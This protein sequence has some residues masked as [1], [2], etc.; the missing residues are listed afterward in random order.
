MSPYLQKLKCK[1]NFECAF[2]T[3]FIFISSLC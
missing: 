3:E 1:L 2:A